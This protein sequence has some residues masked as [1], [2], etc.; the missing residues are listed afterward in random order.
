MDL[1][2]LCDDGAEHGNMVPDRM[3]NRGDGMSGKKARVRQKEIQLVVRGAM[4]AGAKRVTVRL[5]DAFVDVH[6]A[7]DDKP[8][9]ADADEEI[10]L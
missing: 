8:A 5:G 1:Q 10:K 9:A 6:L 4:K 2:R 7:P 3:E